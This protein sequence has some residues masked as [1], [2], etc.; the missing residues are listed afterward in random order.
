MANH[1][2]AIKRNKQNQVRRARN[3]GIR[4]RV[5]G[6]IKA[7][8]LLIE[9]GQPIDQVQEALRIAV[10]IIEKAAVKGTCHKKTASRK[11]SRLTLR[12]NKFAKAAAEPAV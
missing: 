6:V 8:D 9:Q 3:K 11:V 7:V 1:K 4:T 2:S 10:P 5:K 12:V